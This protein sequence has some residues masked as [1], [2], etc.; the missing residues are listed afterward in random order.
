VADSVWSGRLIH[1]SGRNL[2]G[3]GGL[4]TI[5]FGVG[6]IRGVEH[7][8]PLL[9]GDFGGAVVDVGGGMKR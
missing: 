5:A 6:C 7:A 3:C 8:G 1:V 4:R 9:A 2:G